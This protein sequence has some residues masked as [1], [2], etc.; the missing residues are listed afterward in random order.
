MD[1]RVKEVRKLVINASSAESSPSERQE[2]FREIVIRFQDLAYACAYGLLGDSCLA[3]DVAQ[4]S[5]ITAWQKLNQFPRV[6]IRFIVALWTRA[7]RRALAQR[8]QL[9]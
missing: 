6:S 2:S 5:F 8:G 7:T 3:E 9:P 4:E 1:D